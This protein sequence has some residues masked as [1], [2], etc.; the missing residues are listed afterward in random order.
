MTVRLRL[1]AKGKRQK[2]KGPQNP[3]GRE[4]EIP[5]DREIARSNN[6]RGGFL[7]P[8]SR[9]HGICPSPALTLSRS[10]GIFPSHALTFSRSHG[11]C[12]ALA[13]FQSR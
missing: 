9:S 8:L 13:G 5:G 6:R 11:I 1:K 12:P 3:R 10:H 4:V 7:L 2:G